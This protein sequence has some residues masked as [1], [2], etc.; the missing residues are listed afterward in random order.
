MTDAERE[1]NRWLSREKRKGLKDFHVSLKD[2]E[3]LDDVLKDPTRR[4][5][6]YVE[7]NAINRADAEGRSETLTFDD[8]PRYSL[9]EIF[10]KPEK[11]SPEAEAIISECLF[12]ET[13][14]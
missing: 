6:F 9:D 11:V 10:G 14:D 3:S 2:D 1:F 5:E 8:S 13:K 12:K 4:E 7:M